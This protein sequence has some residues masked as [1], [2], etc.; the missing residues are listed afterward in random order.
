MTRNNE[1]EAGKSA[2]V[3]LERRPTGVGRDRDDPRYF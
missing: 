3:T 2:E 1:N